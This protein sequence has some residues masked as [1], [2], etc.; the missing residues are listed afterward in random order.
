MDFKPSTNLFI[1]SRKNKLIHATKI[2]WL[3][4][5]FL[6]MGTNLFFGN[7]F[8]GNAHVEIFLHIINYAFWFGSGICLSISA[9]GYSYYAWVLD[10]KSFQDWYANQAY[11]R[12]EVIWIY[13]PDEFNTFRL[14]VNRLFNLLGFFLGIAI[15][16]ITLLIAF[17]S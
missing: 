15:F 5:F 8:F 16:Y 17:S 7:F 9:A 13:L 6:F 1:L 14:W 11:Y 4:L 2:I 3:I 10:A 12:W